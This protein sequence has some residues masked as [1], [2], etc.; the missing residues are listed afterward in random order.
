MFFLLAALAVRARRPAA[1][2]FEGAAEAAVNVPREPVSETN[3]ARAKGKR[4]FRLSGITCLIGRKFQ[5]ALC[6]V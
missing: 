5:N 4:M 6:R 3:P 1:H 2:R